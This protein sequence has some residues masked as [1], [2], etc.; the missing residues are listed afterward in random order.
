MFSLNIKKSGLFVLSAI[1]F[2]AVSAIPKDN[3]P[4]KNAVKWAVQKASTL[5]IRGATNVNTFGCDIAGYNE[6]DTIYCLQGNNANELVSL[7][8]DLE[9]DITKFD[10]HNRMLTSDLR[11]TLKADEYP[12]LIIRFQSFERVPLADSNK[13]F[14]KGWVELQIAGV[15]RRFEVCYSFIRTAGSQIQLN[16]HRSFSLADFNLVA[17]KKLAGLIKVKDSFNVD[18]NLLLTPVE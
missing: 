7:A 5:T 1:I 11:K 17:P 14:L 4:K 10:C 18:F 9:I 8:G 16:G 15:S 6:P 3:S 13:D 2:T 12:K